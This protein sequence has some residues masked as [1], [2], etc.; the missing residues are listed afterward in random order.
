[1][2]SHFW[3]KLTNSEVNA[4]IKTHKRE[5]EM[6]I[7]GLS[8]GDM[9]AIQNREMRTEARLE[10]ALAEIKRLKAVIKTLRRKEGTK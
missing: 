1:M 6:A 7:P 5:G 9:V 2:D 10:K 4:L 8:K 3:D